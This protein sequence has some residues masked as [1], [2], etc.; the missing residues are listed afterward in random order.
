MTTTVRTIFA[1]LVV[2]VLGASAILAHRTVSHQ[3]HIMVEPDRIRIGESEFVPR[4]ARHPLH[5]QRMLVVPAGKTYVLP[6]ESTWDAIEVSGTLVVSRAHPTAL[7]FTHMQILPGGVLDAGTADNPILHDVEFIIRDVPIDTSRDPY[8]WGNGLLNFG[9]Q[10]RVGRVVGKG[11][12][13][14]AA[15]AQGGSTSLTLS[16]M[17]AGW[18]SGSLL[19]PDMRSPVNTQVRRE[20]PVSIAGATGT[21]VTLSKPLDFEHESIRDPN[22]T[23]VLR[24]RVAHLSR[25]FVIRS[26]NP[27]GTRGHTANIGP[28]ASWD[29]RYNQFV[30]VGRT[31][32]ETLDNTAED[33]AHIGTNQIGKYADHDH[34]T[35]SSLLVRQHIGNTYD[36]LGGS[37]WAVVVHGSHDILV[38]ENVCVDF[39]G[40]CF[41]TEDGYEVR[42]VFRRNVAAYSTGNG[43]DGP[44]AGHAIAEDNP[45]G[46]G[47]GFWFR[48]LANVIEDNEAWNNPIGL[49]LFGQSQIGGGTPVPSARGGE[50]DTPFDMENTGVVSMRGNVTI[51]NRMTGFEAWGVPKFPIDDHVSAHNG[52][53]QYWAAASVR[54]QIWLRNP[55][56]IGQGGECLATSL[57]YVETLR[58]EGGQIRGCHV[59]I[60]GGLAAV[61]ALVRGVTL[62]NSINIVAR[63]LAE[64]VYEDVTHVQLRD[65]PKRYIQYSDRSTYWQPGEPIPASPLGWMIQRGARQR[66]LNWQGTGEDYHLLSSQQIGSAPAWP[67]LDHQFQFPYVPEEGLT[68]LQAWQKYG[69][70]LGGD[71][72]AEAEAVAL[73]GLV[74]GFG[75]RGLDV[76]LGP[77]RAVLTM[78]NMLRPAAVANGTTKMYF[79]LTGDFAN[80]GAVAVVSVD[81]GDPVRLGQ[82]LSASQPHSRQTLTGATSP[83]THE[84]RTWRE[85]RNGN[86]I[87]ASQMVFHYF[88]EG[89]APSLLTA[90]AGP[91][92][93]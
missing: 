46:E 54:N 14:L 40:G 69:M 6:A 50:P 26:E 53:R 37:K 24:P 3:M 49:N 57:A 11:F 13:E 68:M 67:A 20:S 41:A 81:G 78:P 42:N 79:L 64:V 19:L 10:T 43:A 38:E 85:D 74:N 87:P 70:A 35:G 72:V 25:S 28:N 62:Q 48:G 92:R 39:Q 65:Q 56:L 34:H 71:T 63:T 60:N 8:Q 91:A 44:N 77:P 89:G 2:L 21:T 12:V 9:T 59:G 61:T 66:I 36:G 93:R 7:Q 22:G 52:V 18:D 32:G 55:T 75:R 23:V 73:E 15:D 83:G 17:P 5:G 90:P 86:M 82:P 30:G 45:G 4:F 51:G 84:V 58:L 31:K 33:P 80:A 88:V 16:E 1:A 27:A 29:I 47:S 76:D